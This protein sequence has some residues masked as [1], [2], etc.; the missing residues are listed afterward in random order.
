MPDGAPHCDISSVPSDDHINIVAR[1]TN[2]SVFGRLLCILDAIETRRSNPSV[3]IDFRYIPLRQDRAQPNFPYTAKIYGEC[4]LNKNIGSISFFHPHTADLKDI[5]S[6]IYKREISIYYPVDIWEDIYKRYDKLIIPDK[7]AVSIYNEI[8]YHMK[9][10][11][12]KK[13]IFCKKTRDSKTGQLSNPVVPAQNVKD[14]NWII[15]D[16]ICD[17][18]GTFIMLA[19]EIKKTN[20]VVLDLFVTHGIFSKRFTELKKHFW[21]IY[22]TNSTGLKDC[23]E[24]KERNLRILG[25]Y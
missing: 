12:V 25:S 8:A 15:F 17:G 11:D 18:G 1:I 7:G 9:D 23:I 21:K 16:D 10:I 22:S 24:Y 14:E 3:S 5:F 6:G 19:E 20:N 13:F 2:F 4:L